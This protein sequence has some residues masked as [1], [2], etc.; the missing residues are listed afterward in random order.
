MLRIALPQMAWER[1]AAIQT[2]LRALTANWVLSSG[3]R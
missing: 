2:L 3:L 1:C